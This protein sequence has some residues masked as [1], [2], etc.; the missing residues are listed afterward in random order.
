MRGGARLGGLPRW[1]E[2]LQAIAERVVGVHPPEAG[3]VT[4]PSDSLADSGQALDEPVEVVDHDAGMRFAG[5]PEVFLDAEVQFDGAGPE[6]CSAAG[7][8]HGPQIDSQ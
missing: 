3:E 6:P 7:R 4:V 5:G 8:P 1:L 2:E